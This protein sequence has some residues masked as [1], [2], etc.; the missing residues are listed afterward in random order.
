MLDFLHYNLILNEEFVLILNLGNIL[1]IIIFICYDIYLVVFIYVIFIFI[2]VDYHKHKHDL[3]LLIVWQIITFI[4]NN[5]LHKLFYLVSN[6]TILHFLI[7]FIYINEIKF[8]DLYHHNEDN[9]Y[10]C[11][12]LLFRNLFA[13]ILHDL[14]VNNR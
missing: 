6:L 10:H 7:Y 11:I 4:K 1:M 2:F 12:F 9:I 13:L 14:Y 3:I 8:K 5:H